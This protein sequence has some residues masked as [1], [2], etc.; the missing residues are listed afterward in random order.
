MKYIT[1]KRLN[2]NVVLVKSLT[3]KELI[4]IGDG[5]GFSSEPGE[6]FVTTKKVKQIFVLKEQKSKQKFQSL[7]KQTDPKLV[8]LVEEELVKI[9][10]ELDGDLNENIHI[11][12][13]DHLAFAIERQKKGL[14]F[15]NPFNGD[16]KILYRQEYRMAADLIKQVEE[17][18]QIKLPEDEI[19]LIAIHIHAAIQNEQ[20]ETARRKAQLIQE[21]VVRIYREFHLDIQPDS[22]SHQRMLV[23]ARFA[24]ERILEKKN[25]ENNLTNYIMEHYRDY[26]ERIKKVM[27]EI[28][29][30]YEEVEVPDSE[31][32]YLCIHFVRIMEELS[33]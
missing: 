9:Q 6:P 26:F 2:N 22:L 16:L 27:T 15:Q 19:G 4:L 30:E 33:K 13:A 8:A 24:I 21:M 28:S 10:Q 17:V 12:L 11:T 23:H 32:S 20:I 14:E 25:I 29:E 7:L 3:G 18:M 31:I 5:I 1:K